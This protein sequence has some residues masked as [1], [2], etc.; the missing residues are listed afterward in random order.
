MDQE[1]IDGYSNNMVE[2][3]VSAFVHIDELFNGQ[4]ISGESESYQTKTSVILDVPLGGYIDFLTLN[5]SDYMVYANVLSG[6]VVSAM[7]TAE[8]WTEFVG[9][10]TADID[11][12]E[13]KFADLLLKQICKD[14]DKSADEVIGDVLKLVMEAEDYSAMVTGIMGF[15]GDHGVT[16]EDLFE[17]LAQ[18]SDSMTSKLIT[19]MLDGAI[20]TALIAVPPARLIKKMTDV[21]VSSM[22]YTIVIKDIAAMI[23]DGN[24]FLIVSYPFKPIY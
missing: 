16:M 21:V 3:M 2:Q 8:A 5:N 20:D 19:N 18:C 14:F 22:Q 4:L 13:M 9:V 1:L 12:D 17:I 11:L 15:I 10:A 7:E 6:I 23:R 24:D